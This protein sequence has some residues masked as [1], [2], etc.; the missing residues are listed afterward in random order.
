MSATT[1]GTGSFSIT[2]AGQATA[3]T[4]DSSNNTLAGLRDA[5]NRANTNVRAS[6]VQDGDNSYRLMVSSKES[7]T[8]NA[9]TISSSL[10]GGTAPTF[11]NLQAAQDATVKLGTGSNAITVTRSSNLV[12]DLIPGV[13]L[14]LVTAIGEGSQRHRLAGQAEDPGRRPE[15]G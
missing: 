8:A 7:G 2:A 11:S 3:I 12:G 6:I 14:N 5:I 1:I 15:A 9:L 4:V 10:A 13:T